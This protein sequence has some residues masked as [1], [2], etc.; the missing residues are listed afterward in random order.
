MVGVTDNLPPSNHLILKVL[1][2]RSVR[3]F[4]F[5]RLEMHCKIHIHQFGQEPVWNPWKEATKTKINRLC[6]LDEGWMVKGILSECVFKRLST[7]SAL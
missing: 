7:W 2:T 3:S 4:I 1:V 5:L 6:M